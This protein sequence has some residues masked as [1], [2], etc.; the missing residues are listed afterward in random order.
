MIAIT[1]TGINILRLCAAPESVTCSTS[2]YDESVF[3]KLCSDQ[4]IACDWFGFW[5]PTALGYRVLSQVEQ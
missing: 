2:G 5:W 1:R 3:K 4:L